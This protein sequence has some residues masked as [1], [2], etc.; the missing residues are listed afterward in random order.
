VYYEIRAAYKWK[1]HVFSAMSRNN[2]Q[3]GFE[4][5]AVELGW[6]APLWTYW[7]ADLSICADTIWVYGLSADNDDSG[8]IGWRNTKRI[9]RSHFRDISHQAESAIASKEHL[10][11]KNLRKDI[12]AFI[13][14]AE[15]DVKLHI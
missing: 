2:L 7:L 15:L 6:S 5:G 1:E 13:G 8:D 11:W 12:V 9:L 10:Y 4:N 14:A 3:L